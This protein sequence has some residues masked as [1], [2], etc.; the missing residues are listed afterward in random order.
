[1]KFKNIPSLLGIK[2]KAKYYSY[3]RDKY[4]LSNGK[5]VFYSRWLHPACRNN[6]F[7]TATF[8]NTVSEFQKIIS[9]GDFC[10]DIGAH[11]G[12]TAL[13]LGFVTGKSGLVLALE[14]N[15][16]VYHVLEKN[17]RDNHQLCNITSI[18]AAAYAEEKFVE[19]EYSDPSFCNGGRHE[20]I[21]MIKHGHTY[22]LTVWGINLE[23]E[24]RDNYRDLLP[25]LKFIK[26]DTEGYDLYVM[27][28]IKSIIE[29]YKPIIKTEIF[30]HT[31]KEYR[32]N[33]LKFFSELNYTAYR[34]SSEPITYDVELVEDFLT[35][36]RHYDVVAYP[37][38]KTIGKNNEQ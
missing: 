2:E 8:E 23:K 18:M 36:K 19:F 35:D 5:I 10:I 27:M 30:K 16:Y 38:F 24:L 7:V 9:E 20:G 26:I 12:D 14:P 21:P 22:K 17:I 1:M 29:E 11:D 13:P 33:V 34:I 25:K 15:P 32:K 3:R 4:T 31:S 6:Q 28:S 37:K